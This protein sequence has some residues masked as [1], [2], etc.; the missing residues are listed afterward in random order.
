[1]VVSSGVARVFAKEPSIED[2]GVIGWDGSWLNGDQFA[3]AAAA[4]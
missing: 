1:L 4:A 2:A 3:G